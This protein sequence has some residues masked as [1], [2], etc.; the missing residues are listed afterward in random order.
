[1]RKYFASLILLLCT[2]LPVQ[3]G[4]LSGSP[5]VDLSSCP[6]CEF[7]TNKDMNS[8]YAGL[9][10]SGLVIRNPASAQAT[11][12]ASKIPLSGGA[13][14]LDPTWIQ[15]AT[16]S[17][18]GVLNATDWTTFNAKAGLGQ[19]NTFTGSDSFS[20]DITF[21][22]TLSPTAL[23]GDVN[24]YNPTN[25]AT[26]LALRIDGGAADRN[27][28]GLNCTPA[29]GRMLTITN[30]GATNNLV[31]KNQSSST[32]TAADRF[33][34][35]AD[36]TIPI[37]TALALRYDGTTARWRPWSRALANT[38]VTAGSYTK[39]TVDVAGRV[40][41]GTTAASTDLSDTANLVRNNAANTYSGTGLQ[42]LNTVDFRQPVHSSDPATCATGQIQYNSTGS[43]MKFCSATNTWTQLGNAGQAGGGV[44]TYSGPSL[45]FTGT[46]YFP[47]GGGG[48]SSGTET[49]VDVEAP[50]AAT[51]TNY[52]VQ[53]NAALG[54]GNSAVFTW[55]KNASS[56]SLT[57]TIS[58]ASATTCN[59]VTHSFTV[60]QGDLI[61]TQVVVTGTIAAVTA[62]MNTQFGT[63]GSNGT[64]NSG[65][66]GIAYYAASG[67]A[68]SASGNFTG[69]VKSNGA[70]APTQAAC[71]DL[72]NAAAS[73]S[74]DATNA[75]NISSG[76]LL[77]ARYAR[78]C[79]TYM[80]A[81]PTGADSQPSSSAN[82]TA[83]ATAGLVRCS[84][85]TAQCSLPN[86]T[87]LAFRVGVG[88]STCGSGAIACGCG[89]AIYS[90]D[91][92]T[93]IVATSEQT[94]NTSSQNKTVTGL[95]YALTEG[96]EYLVCFA[97]SGTTVSAHG[98]GG[99]VNLGST[100]IV[101]DGQNAAANKAQWNADCTA[102]VTPYACCTGNGTGTCTGFPASLG[103]LA[104][105][106]SSTFVFV[107]AQ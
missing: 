100:N 99:S 82:V 76:T 60:T 37:D 54:L 106:G 85:V 7:T 96:T 57:C 78:T 24:D 91:G 19:N 61:D 38:G 87:T 18:R 15:D 97:N 71:A 102:S 47:P 44:I 55:R 10:G 34:L 14:T 22:G 28:T 23:S 53:L 105:P 48:A 2:A 73:C 25:C 69:A 98:S 89:T 107:V 12:G 32:T 62:V 6:T 63:T 86:A 59:D 3:G 94:C 40:T 41:A 77:V 64:V 20:K 16:G 51:I 35:P 1:M 46:L 21:S 45:T 81:S 13:S 29:D 42:D 43:V 90:S 95:S 103:T 31:L 33:L 17:L 79:N 36:V 39:T 5:T 92:T 8:G 56:Q 65:G 93:K 75:S 74:T 30:I 66:P 70:S 11:P 80:F 104:S 68:V 84:R 4:T 52:Y 49:N 88:A 27:I 67:T 58:G 50:T 83:I 72:S 101:T 26:A 9:N